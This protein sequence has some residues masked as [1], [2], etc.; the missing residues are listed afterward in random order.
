MF[1]AYKIRVEIDVDAP[2]QADALKV[3]QE[4]VD[5]ANKQFIREHRKERVQLSETLSIKLERRS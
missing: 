1:N 3:V 4:A 5:A 2:S